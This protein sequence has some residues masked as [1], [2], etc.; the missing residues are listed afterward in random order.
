M[1][2]IIYTEYGSPDVLQ[3]QE[4]AKPTPKDNEVL[5]KIVAAEATKS[6]CE[7]R[8]FN[9]PVKWFW[10]PLRIAT[11]MFRPKNQ[12]L[13]GYFAGEVE[14][15]GKKVSKYK[16]GDQ[17]F[18]SAGLRM[19]AYAEYLCLPETRSLVAIPE[20]ASFV[21]AAA[22]PLGGFNALHY[23]RRANISPGEQVLIIGAG[24][25][26]GAYGVQ[27]A[28]NMGAEVTAVDS[29]IKEE[30]LRQIGADNFIDYS[31][32]DFSKSVNTYDVIF[33]M[34][35]GNSYNKCVRALKPKGRYLMANPRMVDM[36]HSLLTPMLTDKQVIFAFAGENEEELTALKVMIE[37]GKLKPVVDKVYPLEEAA[38]AHRRVEAEQRLGPVVITMASGTQ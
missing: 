2:A 7:L 20:N 34:V 32:E 13:G 28:K 4:V 30:M 33:D 26:I 36:W 37:E 27:I 19:G 25:S 12:I 6:D 17:I 15:I 21:E 22:V 18:G 11:G 31:Q 3:L 24:G 1:R 5:I 38:D 23:M 9:F 35:A 10:L 14:A 16:A 29:G 8:S